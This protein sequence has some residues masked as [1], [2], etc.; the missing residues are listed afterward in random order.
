MAELAHR[1]P[2]DL[3]T[4]TWLLETDRLLQPED[5]VVQIKINFPPR[6]G[7][8]L[9]EDLDNI[10]FGTLYDF[11][12]QCFKFQPIAGVAGIHYEGKRK[13]RHIHWNIVS[14][15]GV[16]L[17][18]VSTYKANFFKKYELSSW[19]NEPSCEEQ[20]WC[21]SFKQNQ[22]KD[23]ECKYNFFSYPL[24][25]KHDFKEYYLK[26]YEGME[27]VSLYQW[28]NTVMC[29][30]QIEWYKSVGNEI[31]SNALALRQ[32][33]E[34]RIA[35]RENA[36]YRLFDFCKENCQHFKDLQSLRMYLDAYYLPL[37]AL[38]DLPDPANFLT[39][40]KKVAYKLEIWKY[41]QQQG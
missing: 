38:E 9:E 25:E 12:C 21:V 2:D 23:D 31:W 1:F 5:R 41:S 17:T 16:E 39:A 19:F 29:D 13:V 15:T 24:K 3:R 27:V 11:V 40:V 34:L 36:L 32:R 28:E 30:E 6:K 37:F 18:N 20:G 22:V 10:G 26:R 4:Y 8:S 14:K 35:R 33:E 7:K